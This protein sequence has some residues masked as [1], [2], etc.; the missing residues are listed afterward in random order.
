MYNT[1]STF[2]NHFKK[3]VQLIRTLILKFLFNLRVKVVKYTIKNF[4]LKV[5]GAHELGSEPE[6]SHILALFLILMLLKPAVVGFAIEPP[7]LRGITAII[8]TLA[9]PR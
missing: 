1:E 5:V 3:L 4:F 2:S 9:S 8:K 6:I 7:S